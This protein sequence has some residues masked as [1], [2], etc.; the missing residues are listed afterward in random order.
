MDRM[1][2]AAESFDRLAE[3]YDSWFDSPKGKMLFEAEVGAV[4]ALMKDLKHPFLEIGVGSGRFAESLGIEQGIDPSDALIEKARK[5]GVDVVKGVG[6]ALPYKD[7]TFNAVFIL[8]TLCFVNNP[9]KVL[10]EARRILK[11][12][13][14]MITGII[15]SRSTWGLLYSKKK[16]ESHPLYE[17]ARFYTPSELVDLVGKGGMSV[18]AFSSTLLRSPFDD[19]SEELVLNGLREDAGYVC[20]LSRKKH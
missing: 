12:G 3:E 14:G 7:E 16:Y 9:I 17:H 5:R 6:E 13:G 19:Q 20:I 11:P 2:N 8:L 15:N 18:E 1:M 10:A 4:K